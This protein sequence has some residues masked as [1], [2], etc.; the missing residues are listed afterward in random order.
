MRTVGDPIP[1]PGRA[2]QVDLIAGELCLDFANTVEPR[3]AARHGGQPREYLT[4]YHDLIA[5]AEHA[6]IVDGEEARHLLVAAEERPAEAATAVRDAV[7]LREAIYRSFYAL[8]KG[9]TPERADLD[10]LGAAYARAMGRARLAATAGGFALAWA[11]DAG[12]LDRPLWP[13]ARSAVDLLTQ[14]DPARVKDC[15]TG[16]E[17]CGWLFHDASK[18]RSRRWCS[19]GDCGTRVKELRRR[20]RQRAR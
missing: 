3:V 1:T 15:P 12:A 10:A 8:A 5:W 4:G 20:G 17:G 13:V 6:G 9:G 16:E 7:A 18:N 11:D 19:M 14:G 2:G